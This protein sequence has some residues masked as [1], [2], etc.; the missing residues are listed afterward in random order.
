MRFNDKTDQRD[1]KIDQ[2]LK[3]ADDFAAD[4]EDLVYCADQGLFYLW[5]DSCWR[6]KLDIQI[7]RYLLNFE[8]VTYLSANGLKNF[9]HRLAVLKQRRLDDFN[10]G[11]ILDFTNGVLDIQTGQFRKHERAD[12]STYRLPYKYDREA[13]C[14]RW[15]QFVSECLE[16]DVSRVSVLQEFMGYCLGRDNSFHKALVCVGDGR[17]GKGTTFYVISKLVGEENCSALRLGDM[18]NKETVSDLVGKLVNID[19]DTD[20]T[21]RGFESDFRRISAGDTMVARKLYKD[22]FKFTPYCKLIVGANELPRIADKTHGFYDR[23]IILPYNVSFVGR[24][25]RDLKPKLVAE[26]SGIL[27]WALEGRRRLYEYGRFSVDKTLQGLVTELKRENNPIEIF[28]DENVRVHEDAYTSKKE[29]YDEYMAWCKESGHRAL[30]RVKFGKELFRVFK[31]QTAKDERTTDAKRIP[32][33]PRLY[34]VKNGSPM[35]TVEW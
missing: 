16:K 32:I 18:S 35:E 5:E 2:I 7:E 27:N 9:M 24:E 17:N 12:L 4:N 26:I 13:S 29:M 28:I 25:D 31:V 34:L 6:I 30:S 21:A 11:N 15:L 14:G 19:A 22:V 33:W 1:D 20:A 23:L 10:T 8:N 3:M